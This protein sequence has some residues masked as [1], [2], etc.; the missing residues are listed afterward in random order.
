MLSIEQKINI[1]DEIIA[2]MD[3]DEVTTSLEE[4]MFQYATFVMSNENFCGAKTAP[5]VNHLW[6]LR[7]IVDV[8]KETQKKQNAAPTLS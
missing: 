4:I 7:L 6:L 2:Y 1:V 8:I 3:L 5:E